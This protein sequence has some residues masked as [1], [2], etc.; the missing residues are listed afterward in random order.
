MINWTASI[1]YGFKL[2]VKTVLNA[3]PEYD[4]RLDDLSTTVE[5]EYPLLT[6]GWGGDMYNSGNSEEW[7]FIKHSV[8]EVREWGTTVDP[9]KMLDSLTDEALNQLFEF[10]ADT[11]VAI[12]RPEWRMMI[13]RG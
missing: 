11:G 9:Q 1:G 2:D 8:V 3:L 4:E 6:M 10:V 13:C 7:I 5:R 12:G